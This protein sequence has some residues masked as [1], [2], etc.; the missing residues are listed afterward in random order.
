[1]QMQN[2]KENIQKKNSDVH[3][4]HV[5]MWPFSSCNCRCVMCDIWT[6]R[7]HL[8][9]PLETVSALAQELHDAGV[10]GVL[11]TGGEAMMHPDIWQICEILASHSL[12]IGL[13]SSG[14][15]LKRYAAQI[16]Q[17]C[18]EL[19]V[20]LDGPPQLHDAI[21]R[22]KNAHL[23]VI[24]GI[25]AIR[26][27]R[28]DFPIQARCAVHRHNFRHLREIIRFA[29]EIG[30]S[31]I[32]FLAA[33]VTSEAFN[34][35]EPWLVERQAT[36]AL[37]LEELPELEREIAALEQEC[38]G[39]FASQFI[40][41]SASLLRQ[42]LLAYYRAHNEVDVF[43]PVTCNAPWT[44]AVVEPNGDVRPCFFHKPYGNIHRAGSL[45]AVLSSEKAVQFR[46]NLDV[47][48]NPVCQRCV[49]TFQL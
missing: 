35:S 45:E 44:S 20:S 13:L 14:I 34:R 16:T 3:L 17:Y 39:E 32:S 2:L 28:P 9:M 42:K 27:L 4:K 19:V 25:Q 46:R 23:R 37:T 48:S 26:Q 5:F 47:R 6:D 1:M 38:D 30:F 41:E 8:K 49:C 33:D 31:R 40:C 7:S 18:C 36:I 21:R 29:Q 11:L 43:P 10:D 24:E 22:V 12:Q 15:M